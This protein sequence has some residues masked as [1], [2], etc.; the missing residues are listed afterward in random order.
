MKKTLFLV[1]VAALATACTNEEST[2]EQSNNVAKGI[3]FDATIEGSTVANTR[4]ELSK[5]D[6]KYPFFWYAETDRINLYAD[7]VVNTAGQNFGV[8]T[9]WNMSGQGAQYKATKSASQGQFTAVSDNNWIAFVDDKKVNVVATYPTA[10]T[11][12]A[13]VMDP[14]S[15]KITSV[16]LNTGDNQ[17]QAVAFN[18]IDAPMYSISEGQRA[19]NYESVGEKV[20][21]SFKRAF[22]AL[23]FSSVSGNDQYNDILGALLAVNVS[24]SGGEKDGKTLTPTNIAAASATYNTADMKSASTGNY[25]NKPILASAVSNATTTLAFPAAWNS[26]DYLYM[27]IYPVERIVDNVQVPENYT[28]TYEYAHVTLTKNLQSNANWNIEN[29]VY[30]V[31]DLDIAKDFPYIVTRDNRLIVFS[32]TFSNIENKADKSKIDWNNGIVEKTDIKE[33]ISKVVL[34]SEELAGLKDFT[35]LTSLKLEANTS[36]PVNTFD[37]ALAAQ[38]DTLNLPKVTEYKDAQV[39]S[40]LAALN[41]NAYKFAED[42]VYKNFFNTSTQS[43]LVNLKIE[44]VESLR[45]TF[46]YDRTITFKDY[47]ALE[48]VALNP[49]GV[50]LPANAFNG[51]LSLK[52]VT[53]IVDIS[54]A[55]CAFEGAGDATTNPTINVLNAIIPNYAFKNANIKDIKMNGTQVAPTEIG[56]C[57]FENSIIELMDLSKATSIGTKAFMNATSFIGTTNSTTARGVVTI[58]AEKVEESIL[59]GTAVIRVQFKNATSIGADV[60]SS[61]PALKQIKFLKTVSTINTSSANTFSGISTGD[62]DMFVATAQTG[63]N[64]LSWSGNNFKSITKEDIAW[65]E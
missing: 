57:A 39:F 60:F 4:G 1:C 52:S 19:E 37:A 58:I 21:L 44:A 46:G 28:V 36:I 17:A 51:C 8:V 25:C 45:P 2:F 20:S 35:S 3:V 56:L 63:V 33:I 64:G 11:V 61:N 38:I 18:Q 53:G 10:T 59:S 14:N 29:A 55:P 42:E 6:G 23:R 16:E 65:G 12:R 47:T 7:N 31:A 32:G 43:T 9:D 62:I 13:A 5:N 54:N 40:N 41:L 30:E 49:K 26:K 50:A 27:S 15:K 48:T 22:P 34:T 24:M